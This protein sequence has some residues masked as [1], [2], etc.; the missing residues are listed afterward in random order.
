[1]KFRLARCLVTAGRKAGRI[2][3]MAAV[4]RDI[5]VF[6]DVGEIKVM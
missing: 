1:M 6:E 4:L 3:L 5:V 2:A